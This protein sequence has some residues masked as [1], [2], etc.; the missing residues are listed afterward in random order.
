MSALQFIG[1]STIVVGAL[2]IIGAA[3]YD[4]YNTGFENGQIPLAS[5]ITRLEAEASNLNQ[6]LD[7]LADK[8]AHLAS[9][10]TST[11]KPSNMIVCHPLTFHVD[12]VPKTNPASVQLSER[13]YG[14]PCNGAQI[15]R[16][17]Q[18]T[19]SVDGKPVLTH[20]TPQ[21][22]LALADN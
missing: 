21:E 11:R 6:E 1:A 7:A 9:L 19:Y 22:A 12:G 13:Y 4:T 20:I 18:I 10:D 14:N 15:S 5:Q 3:F 8:L 2:A 17:W 16:A